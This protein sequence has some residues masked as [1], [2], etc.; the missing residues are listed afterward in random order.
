MK[1]ASPLTDIPDRVAF[2]AAGPTVAA[3]AAAAALPVPV[4]ALGLAARGGDYL[5]MAKPRMNALVVVTTAV[6]FYMA[7]R[8]GWA[9]EY[10]APFLHTLVGTALTAAGAS[11]L[12]QYV[13]R[14]LD[15]KMPRTAN[16]PLPAGR[17]APVEALALGVT[18][19]VAGVLYLAGLVN[20]LAATLAAVTLGTY[21]FLYTPLKT[22]TTLCT[23]VGAV[24]GAIPPMIGWAAAEGA[25]G[26]GA[27]ALFS[28]LF[29][30]QLPHFL[31]IAIL[32][33]DDYAA[34]GMR[35]LPVIDPDLSFTGRQI[36]LWALALVPVSLF[37]AVVGMTGATYFVAAAF[38][39]VAFLAFSV[40]C[41]L[42][43]SR[44]DA[45]RLFLASI[46]YLPAL[47][48]VMMIGRN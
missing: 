11:V 32:Y 47:L 30:W 1:P 10:W 9:A 16:R 13:E 15:G 7:V 43:G 44:T 25:L 29:F 23:V 8:G 46:L 33:R 22:R 28:I 20:P 12:N 24:P 48:G 5:E 35:M 27:W 31:A 39:G 18:L 17:V 4:E 26:P 45:R 41:G 14:D 40:K 3:G 37:P 34:G 36:V 2:A 19:G 42:S 6:G 38:L 21:V